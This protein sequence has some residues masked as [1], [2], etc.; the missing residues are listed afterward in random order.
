MSQIYLD[1]HVRCPN[2]FH[3]LMELEFFQQIFKKI[4]KY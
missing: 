2:S 4:V 3:I 1:L